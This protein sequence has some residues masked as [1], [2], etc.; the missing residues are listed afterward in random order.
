[1]RRDWIERFWE[2]VDRSGG[3]DACWPWTG[4]FNRAKRRS[5][6][7]EGRPRP[8]FR[9]GGGNGVHG[10]PQVVVYAHRLALCIHDGTLLDEHDG[11]EA[12]HVPVRCDNLRCVNPVHLYWGT[13][14]ENRRDRYGR[15]GEATTMAT[16]TKE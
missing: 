3:P 16:R 2:K 5:W 1:M 4:G 9:L 8:I 10:G 14:E 15:D 13:S 7:A 12:C 11:Q 6:E